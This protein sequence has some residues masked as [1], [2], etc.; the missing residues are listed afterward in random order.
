MSDTRKDHK[1]R[2]LWNG[3][4]QRKDGK[5]EYKYQ[6]ASGKRKTVYSWKLTPS[7]TMPKGKRNDLS[8]REKEQLIQ[9]ELNSNLVPGGGEIPRPEAGCAPQ[10]A[11]QLQLRGEHP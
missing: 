6:D 5:Y 8:L 2:K 11:G 1:G 10:H 9:K 7:D 3:E 4:S